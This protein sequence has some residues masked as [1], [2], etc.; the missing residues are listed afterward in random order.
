[1]VMLQGKVPAR[2]RLFLIVNPPTWFDT[3]WKIMKN[4]LA[5]DFRKK[6]HMIPESELPNFLAE[7]YQSFLPDDM[8]CGKVPTEG[9][10]KDFVKFRKYLEA[11]E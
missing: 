5:P 4:M 8:E 3:I 11:A 1:M 10:V 9:I 6:V 2:V 7:G